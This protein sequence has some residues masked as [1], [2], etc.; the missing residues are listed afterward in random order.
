MNLVVSKNTF[1]KYELRNK[2][3]YPYSMSRETALD[4]LISHLTPEDIVVSTT[5]VLSRE[6]FELREQKDQSH[7]KDFLTVGGMGHSNQIALG[8][9]L[10]NNRNVYCLDGDGSIIMHMGS[11]AITANSGAKNLKHIL[12]HK[13]YQLIY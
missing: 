11:L 9:A 5:G 4:L 7:D 8:I 12:F 3:N 6:L 13:V 2:K 1:S 10:E